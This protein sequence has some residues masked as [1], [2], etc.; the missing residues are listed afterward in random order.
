MRALAGRLGVTPMSLYHHIGD[1][2]GLLRALSD[3]VYGGVLERAQNL[4]DA[5]G[6]VRA[7]LVHYYEAVVRHPHLALAIFGEPQAFAGASVLITERLTTLLA[8]VTRQ[9][10]LWRDILID[11][12]HGSALALVSSLDD[13]HRVDALGERYRQ[14]LDCLLGH[15][16][17]D[18]PAS[19]G[20][21]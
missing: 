18:P 20:D 21:P 9:P 5:R 11:H 1:R 4:Q 7:L 13:P 10:A 19:D 16:M 3:R 15:V 17:D 6:G 12:V 14:A 2:A 8:A